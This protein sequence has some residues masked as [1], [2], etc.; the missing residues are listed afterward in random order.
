MADTVQL[1]QQAHD[2][3]YRP[4]TITDMVSGDL[5][6][7][8][9]VTVFIQWGDETTSQY[10]YGTD[11]EV[12]RTATGTYYLRARAVASGRYFGKVETNAN[13]TYEGVGVFS[14]T[15]SANKFTHST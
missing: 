8:D 11:A 9:G 6:N 14:G 10:V 1:G 2:W 12:Q 5:V 15:V 3:I 4:F 13:D 7:P